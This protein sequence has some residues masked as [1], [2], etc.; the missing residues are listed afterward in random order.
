MEH[1]AYSD[2]APWWPLFSPVQDY[3]EE[4]SAFASL[5]ERS[6]IPVHE[7]LELGSGGGHTAFH[8]KARFALTLTDRSDDMLALSRVLN[9]ECGHARGDMR[10]LR[11]GRRFDAVFVHDA[12]DY[13]TTEHDL[14]AAITTATAHMRVGGLLLLAPDHVR[15]TFAPGT[16]CGGTDGADGRG[17]R[18]LEWSYDPDPRDTEVTTEYA[19]LLR[20]PDGHVEAHAE[21]HVTGLFPI[22]TWVRLLESQGLRVEI[23]TEEASGDWTPRRFFLAHR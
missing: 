18:Y 19:F 5:L 4:A 6:A 11:L 14:A 21:T 2:L 7:V 15:E 12:V 13:M 20:S 9:P 8:L 16:D 23:V 1:R 22:A 3:A 17:L 10:T